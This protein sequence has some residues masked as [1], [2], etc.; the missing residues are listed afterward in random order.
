MQE[1]GY[2]VSYKL[3]YHSFDEIAVIID[4]NE[5]DQEE[6]ILIIKHRYKTIDKDVKI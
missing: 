6:V 5:K 4:S 1:I 2:F 3:C